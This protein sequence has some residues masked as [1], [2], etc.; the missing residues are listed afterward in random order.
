M[1]QHVSEGNSVLVKLDDGEDL[2]ASLAKIASAYEIESGAVLWGIGMLR[3][4]EFGYYNGK[5]Y[6]RSHVA[7]GA[8]LIA[9]H[10]SLAMKADPSMHL[11][12]AFAG[13]DHKMIGG[14]LFEA[15]VHNVNEILISKFTLIDLDRVFNDRSGLKELVVRPRQAKARPRK[16]R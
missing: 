16:S 12:V 13:R 7:E 9:L 11:H 1:M 6:E 14:H 3:E 5:S 2:F 10:G 15:T 8:E 4:I